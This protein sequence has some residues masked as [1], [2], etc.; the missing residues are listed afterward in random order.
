MAAHLRPGGHAQPWGSLPLCWGH[1]CLVLAHAIRLLLEYTDSSYEEKMYTMGDGN[2]ILWSVVPTSAQP[3]SPCRGRLWLPV[4]PPPAGA[5]A[6]P[7]LKPCEGAVSLPRQDAGRD[8]WAWCRQLAGS[9]LGVCKAYASLSG[10]E[11]R[12]LASVLHPP[13]PPTLEWETEGLRL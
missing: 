4:Q 7:S 11:S 10:T 8:R 5:A 12:A 13:R 9:P 3:G 6:W 1:W 2:G